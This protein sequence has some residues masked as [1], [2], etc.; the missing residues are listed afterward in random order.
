MPIGLWII[1]LKPIHSLIYLRGGAA[2][3]DC[4]MR[5]EK[6]KHYI[7]NDIDGLA[8][9]LFVDALN[10]KYRGESRWIS[11]EEFEQ[12]KNTDGYIRFCW[13]FG[14]NGR[15]YLYSREIEP[16][17]KAIH[18]MCFAEN[19]FERKR[20]YRAVLSELVKYLHVK[21]KS[22][23]SENLRYLQGLESLERLQ[24]LERL[25]GLQGLERLEGDYADVIIPD[26]A[27]IYCDIPYAGTNKYNNGEFDMVR[28]TTW[29][30]QQTKPIY[31]SSYDLPDAD[32]QEIARHEKT[33]T[34]CASKV[35]HV[36]EKLYIPRRDVS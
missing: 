33:C 12:K 32:F 36:I 9:Q 3:T 29:A 16:Y 15:D 30:K 23:D 24:G 8:T 20:K 25:E 31:V 14:N 5:R 7:I 4:A 18:E 28:F 2:V 22:L 6:Y 35:N 26:D 11:R 17:K 21:N 27:V 34:M 13:S 10:G 19:E 1:C